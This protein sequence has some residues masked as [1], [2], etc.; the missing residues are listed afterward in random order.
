[1]EIKQ[2]NIFLEV[3]EKG[4]FTAAA[5]SL[6]YAQSTISDTIHALESN[7][8]CQLF[9]R[10]GKRIFLT[11]QGH[12]LIEHAQRLTH[13]HKDILSTFK[14]NVIKNIRIGITESLS[15]YKFPSFFRKYLN[16]SMVNTPSTILNKNKCSSATTGSATEIG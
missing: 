9:E 3:V 5:K 12:Q 7:L 15:T 13:L 14:S 10:I 11:E 16:K 6:N 2:L 8:E 4:S 1:M